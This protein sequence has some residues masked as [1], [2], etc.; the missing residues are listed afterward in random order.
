MKDRANAMNTRFFI[1]DV[2]AE[3]P[4]EGNQLATFFD[5]GMMD[6]RQMQSIARETNFSETTFITS[7]KERQGGY[8]VRIFTPSE[9]I[10]FAGHPTL[11]TA[12]IIR[13]KL[14]G[15]KV[16]NVALN[17]KVGQI[18]VGFTRGSNLA[19]MR[20]NAP[21]FGRRFDP[22]EAAAILGLEKKDI[23]DR[24]QVEEVS[25]GLPF[26]IIPLRSLQALKRIRVDVA[27]LRSLISGG[28]ASI[29]L[30]FSP[31]GKEGQ[32]FSVRVFP[33]LE[34]IS[35]DPATGSGNGCLAAYMVK[36]HYGGSP[37]VET[38][39]GQGYEI[40]RPSTLYLKAGRNDGEIVVNVGGR[41]SEVASGI[42]K[43]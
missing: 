19:W 9:E 37:S 39:V 23:D 18:P 40:G 41:I 31:G 7:R 25:T 22:K 13:E 3:R 29:P 34:G 16:E 24:W 27:A 2:F 38:R 10:P 33:V 17:L 35:E 26:I 21:E 15:K 43:A 32:G 8:D 5:F 36:N 30:A 4:L 28:T 1:T 12:H 11:G 42:W 6:G 14:I 20:Q